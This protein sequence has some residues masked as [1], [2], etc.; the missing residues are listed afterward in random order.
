MDWTTPD[1]Q[2]LAPNALVFSRARTVAKPRQ[3]ASLASDGAL[4]WGSCKSQGERTHQTLI[5]LDGKAHR[6]TCQERYRPCRHVL[7]L[8]LLWQRKRGYFE[9]LEQAADWV[10]A[11]LA[12]PA[13]PVPA[14]PADA[15]AAREQRLGNRLGLMEQGAEELEQWLLD[16]VRQGLASAQGQPAEFWERI[17]ARMV[18]AKL[19]SI[20]RRIRGFPLLIGQP[21]WHGQLL[22]ELS[23]LYLFVQGFRQLNGLPEPLQEE[24]LAYGGLAQKKEALLGQTGVS[25][26]WLVLGLVVGEDDQLRYRR[27]WLLGEQSGRYA[28]ILDFA[29]GRAP[30]EGNWKLGSAL[31]GELVYYP[32]AWPLRALFKQVRPYPQALQ[33]LQGFS[34]LTAFSQKYAEALAATPWLAAFPA[35]LESVTLSKGQQ[36]LW[37]SDQQGQALPVRAEPGLEW[38]L[39]S[40]AAGEELACFGEWDGARF[41]PAT[42]IKAGRVVPLLNT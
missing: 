14:A 39:L 13:A 21:D 41:A 32:A 25:D 18:D 36:Q 40:V 10:Q 20:A 38:V 35:L 37:L 5:S 19:P 4:L 28:L 11:A 27:T 15:Q 34:D 12:Q 6:C 1:I 9:K 2:Q 29:W 42:V 17:A 8:L 26:N 24:L 23:M 31:Q 16:F 22:G 7:A 3:W 33:G 30:F